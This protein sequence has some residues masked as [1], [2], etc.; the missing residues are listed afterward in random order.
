MA[1]VSSFDTCASL[2]LARVDEPFEEHAGRKVGIAP[3]P[4]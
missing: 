3:C 2:G 1:S 4:Q